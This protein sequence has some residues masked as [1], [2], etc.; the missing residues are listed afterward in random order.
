MGYA[1]FAENILRHLFVFCY[2]NAC[3]FSSSS[4]RKQPSF[5]DAT[6]GVSAK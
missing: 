5:R 1:T 2:P 6:T 3:F 4:L